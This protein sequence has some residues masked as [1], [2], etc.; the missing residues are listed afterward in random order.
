MKLAA[1]DIRHA[2][3][4]I[5][6]RPCTGPAGVTRWCPSCCPRARP[7]RS[8]GVKPDGQPI[9]M[10]YRGGARRDGVDSACRVRH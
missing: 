7:S 5:N 1:N 9:V 3:V 2:T 10:V 6:N 8:A 4:V